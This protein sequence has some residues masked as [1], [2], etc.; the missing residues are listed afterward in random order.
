MRKAWIVGM[1][2][3]AVLVVVELQAQPPMGPGGMWEHFSI[4]FDENQ[5]GQVTRDEFERGEDRFAK[6]D[7]NADGVLTEDDFQGGIGRHGGMLA[8]LA[9]GD[10]NGEVTPDEWQEFLAAIDPDGD[11]VISDEERVAFFDSRR[12]A[13]APTRGHDRKPP[14]GGGLDWD[15]DG[16]LETDDL[17]KLFAELDTNGDQTLQSDELPQFP[18]RGHRGSRGKHGGGGS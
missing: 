15:E 9:D 11:G 2:V 3:I 5:D 8:R 17:N 18:G 1:V 7:R 6:L 4:R 16:V 10:R 13:D 14:M 12:P